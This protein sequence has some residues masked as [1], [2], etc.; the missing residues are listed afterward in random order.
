MDRLQ[1]VLELSSLLLIVELLSLH[2]VN[3]I[4]ILLVFKVFV[5]L[6]QFFQFV[7]FQN[8]LVLLSVQLHHKFLAFNVYLVGVLSLISYLLSKLSGHE[9]QFFLQHLCLLLGLF[10]FSLII[11]VPIIKII[12]SAL[13]LKILLNKIAQLLFKSFSDK[14]GLMSYCFFFLEFIFCL[15]GLIVRFLTNFVVI[16]QVLKPCFRFILDFLMQLIKQL[17]V[18]L[19]FIYLIQIFADIIFPSRFN[20]LLQLSVFSFNLLLL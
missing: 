1:L 17:V 20:L 18:S 7:L 15:L 16:F 9:F 14:L 6:I 11:R 4:I 5:T 10:K 2:F 12:S 8:V 13:L 3:L 19:D